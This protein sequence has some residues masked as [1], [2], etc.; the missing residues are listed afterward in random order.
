MVFRLKLSGPTKLYLNL[1]NL[2]KKYSFWASL[3]INIIANAHLFMIAE[4]LSQIDA[5]KRK[6]GGWQ[7]IK[8]RREGPSWSEMRG[9]EGAKPTNEA[10]VALLLYLSPSLSLSHKCHNVP[11]PLS[12][13]SSFHRQRGGGEREYFSSSEM[14]G[15]VDGWKESSRQRAEGKG[16]SS[17][18][19][20]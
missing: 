9:K 16:T 13:S 20:D 15:V 6:G 11:V 2:K 14:G 10:K 1:K 17:E 7:K 3:A 5:T 12:F 18:L 19:A 8:D 4:M